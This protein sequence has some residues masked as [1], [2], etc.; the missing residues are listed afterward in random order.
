M[1]RTGFFHH[2]GSFLLFAAT[3]L[4]LVTTISAPVVDNISLL[5]VDLA[6]GTSEHQSAITFGTFGYC[7]IHTADGHNV[8]SPRKIGYNPAAVIHDDEH[9]SNASEDSTKALTRVMVLHPIATGVAFIAFL[10]AVGAGVIGSFLGALVSLV[11]F[12]ITVIVLITD[13]VLFH[14]VKKHVNDD[15]RGASAK[16]GVGLWLILAAAIALLIGTLV[17]FF[18]CCSARLHRSRNHSNKVDPAYVAQPR[19]RRFF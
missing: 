15:L 1:A 10:L 14:I 6:N 11:A 2:I 17:V 5:K 19:R 8:C 18:T 9:F 16:Y 13:F 12:L 4:L 7:T 3:I